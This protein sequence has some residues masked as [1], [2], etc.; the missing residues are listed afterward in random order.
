M[1]GLAAGAGPALPRR[2]IPAAGGV[3]VRELGYTQV[4]HR[5][6]AGLGGLPVAV[7]TASAMTQAR[8]RLGP[9]RCASC[10]SCCAARPGRGAVAGTAGGAIDGRSDVAAARRLAVSQA[11]GGRRRSGYDAAAAG[12]G[13]LRGLFCQPTE[14]QTDLQRWF[15]GRFQLA[16]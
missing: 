1:P 11:R 7:P 6:A 16:Q 3:P 9:V 8:R 13:Q 2:G 12:P 4:W 10:S 5:V 15:P 14:V